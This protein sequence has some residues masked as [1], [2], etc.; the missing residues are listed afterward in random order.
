MI[1]AV[2]PVIF[3]NPVNPVFR[4]ATVNFSALPEEISRR[5]RFWNA[6]FAAEFRYVH[7]Y[8]ADFLGRAES[9][10]SELRVERFD[11]IFRLCP[12][13]PRKFSRRFPDFP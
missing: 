10:V 6:D 8:F 2:F 12:W 4:E 1:A 7:G 5:H 9:L 3:R 13:Q 11:R